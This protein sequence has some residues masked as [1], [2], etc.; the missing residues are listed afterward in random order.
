[1]PELRTSAD[2]RGVPV[3]SSW[4]FVSSGVGVEVGIGAGT[5][6][7]V[8]CS[9]L[10]ATVSA[11]ADSVADARGGLSGS[12]LGAAVRAGADKAAGAGG[13]EGVSCSLLGATVK[14]GADKAAGAGGGGA[15]LGATVRVDADEAA[16]ASA[17]DI[18]VT[19]TASPSG[20]SADTGDPVALSGP[21]WTT[22]ECTMY[23]GLP[24][25][26][27]TSICSDGAGT[28]VTSILSSSVLTPDK[29]DVPRN[30]ASSVLFKSARSGCSINPANTESGNFSS[31]C[32]FASRAA[33]STSPDWEYNSINNA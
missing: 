16:G 27:T 3:G 32:S 21:F 18:T 25:T 12:L 6:A 11:G 23:A 14:A 9:L 2:V 22:G 33:G 10:G 26:S 28:E 13:R 5:G 19:V 29:S 4:E 7:E 8:N 24:F 30:T 15:L 31:A 20:G 1:L 17:G